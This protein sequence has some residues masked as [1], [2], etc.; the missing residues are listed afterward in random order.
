MGVNKLF[1]VHIPRTSGTSMCKM[2]TDAFKRKNKEVGDAKNAFEIKNFQ[3]SQFQK[4]NF[5]SGHVDFINCIRELKDFEYMTILREP[6][7]RYF[8]HYF[9]QIKWQHHHNYNAKLSN[10][11]RDGYNKREF[12]AVTWQLGNH[13]N[14]RDRNVCEAEA[15]TKA[16]EHLN[17]FKWILFYE[18][19]E[20]DVGKF[21]KEIGVHHSIEYPSRQKSN[22]SKKEQQNFNGRLIDI[23]Y[24][25][26]H[27][28]IELYNYAKELVNDKST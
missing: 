25:K 6:I 11:I 5:T 15:L 13:Y 21:R 12:N 23:V 14:V 1:F 17:R 9:W 27:M 18:N 8:S 16:K 22:N 26:N 4:F 28:D 2:L 10:Y 24:K 20:E 7:D 3:M 19:L